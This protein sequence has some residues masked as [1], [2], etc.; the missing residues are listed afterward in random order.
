MWGGAAAA[1]E[2]DAGGGK[3][4]SKSKKGGGSKGG[5][6][7][8]SSTST[9]TSADAHL[10][11]TPRATMSAGGGGSATGRGVNQLIELAH[12]RAGGVLTDEEFQEAKKAWVRERRDGREANRP[13]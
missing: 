11:V 7:S 12:L 8:S 1:S 5:A 4:S 13:P 6:S 2:A 9:A 3:K 10:P